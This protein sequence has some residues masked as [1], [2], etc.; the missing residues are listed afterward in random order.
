MRPRVGVRLVFDCAY[1]RVMVMVMV[2]F[3]FRLSGIPQT[4]EAVV[5][6]SPLDDVPPLMQG[7]Q[8]ACVAGRCTDATVPV[9]FGRSLM[10]VLSI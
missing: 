1:L 8:A 9:M 7:A 2:R 3:R 4:R 6:L 5:Y 10:S